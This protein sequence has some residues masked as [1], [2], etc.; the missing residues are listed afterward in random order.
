MSRLSRPTLGLL[1]AVAL[2]A[3][4]CGASPSA[5]G[6]GSLGVRLATAGSQAKSAFSSALGGQ[7]RHHGPR[8]PFP[9]ITLSAE[10]QAQLQ[11]LHAASK[12]PS[13]PARPPQ[14]AVKAALSAEP[15]DAA[16]LRAALTPPARPAF[17]N[18][19]RL[20][21]WRDILTPAQ[22]LASA[23]KLRE[24]QPER[25]ARPARPR[26]D[27]TAKLATDLTLTE[28]QQTQLKALVTQ[29][30]ANKPAKPPAG[31][32][33]A[34][35]KFLETGDA[36]ALPSRPERQG[37]PIDA[38]VDFVSSL[39]ATQRAALAKQPFFSFGRRGPGGRHGG[40][41]GH[42]GENRGGPPPAP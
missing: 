28:M 38:I 23:A 8:L 3:A 29:M 37:P 30:A 6:E 12:P 36:S 18:A 42:R 21:A 13:R 17:D 4:G 5:D 11:A 26:P 35:A 15:F 1:A 31:R 39:D 27:F 9:G 10:Q 14:G 34:M 22:R 2:L 24:P 41:G 33:E 16:A 7:G 19:A 32:R 40:R 20:T 25:E